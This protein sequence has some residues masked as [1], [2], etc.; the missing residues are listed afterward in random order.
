MMY[1]NS[2][3]TLYRKT[4]T[5]YIRSVIE[6]VF[7]D[8]TSTSDWGKSGMTTTHPITLFIPISSVTENIEFKDGYDFIVKG[9]STFEFDNTSEATKSSSL[10]NLK[11]LNNVYSVVEADY[12]SFGSLNM[13]HYKLLLK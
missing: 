3:I 5:V 10:R 4:D 1:T 7:W 9:V 2:D 13:Q 8:E 11:N 6:N 12:K